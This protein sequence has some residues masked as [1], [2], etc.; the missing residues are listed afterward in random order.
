MFILILVHKCK[1]NKPTYKSNDQY[2][3]AFY[4]NTNGFRKALSFP[5]S[6]GHVKANGCNLL[7]SLSD[8]ALILKGLCTFCTGKKQKNLMF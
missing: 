1:K 3:S 5:E 4:S 6:Q 8:D 7:N 2:S